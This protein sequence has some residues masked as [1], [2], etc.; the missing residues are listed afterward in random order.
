MKVPAT[1][2]VVVAAGLISGSGCGGGDG[3][4]SAPA[5][6][7]SVTVLPATT[8]IPP[9]ST[10]QL[11]ATSK[12]FNGNVVTG[13]TVTWATSD[14]GV[15]RV[16]PTGLVTG[17][18]AG[19]ATI[20]AMSEGQ[21]GTATVNV[22][23]VFAALTAGFTHTC[24]LTTVGTAYCWGDN[25]NGALGD[26]TDSLRARPTAVRGGLHFATLSAGG[27]SGLSNGTAAG[28][29]TC[30]VTPAGAA[31]CWG[32]NTA[33]ALGT[34][35]SSGPETC[36]GAQ[37]CSTT[38]LAVAGGLQFA[39]VSVGGAHVCGVTIGG[40]AYCWGDN[41]FG[42]LGDGSRNPRPSPGL[43]SGGLTFAAVTAGFTH[44]CGL[45]P[46]GAAYCWGNNS[47]GELGD[48]SASFT[49]T[50]PVAVTG[51]L[52]FATL[53]A[54]GY[55][56]CGATATGAA[57][58]W[59]DNFYGPLGDSTTWLRVNPVPV[60]GGL[61]FVSVTGGY[62]HTCAVGTGGAGYCWGL[63][64]Y[65]QL[66]AG[67]SNFTETT[68]VAIAGGLIFASVSAGAGHTCA[69]TTARVAYCWGLNTGSNVPVKVAYQ[70]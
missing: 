68:P 27:A 63:N 12:D 28:D 25:G 64:S 37:P 38:P 67:S 58:C 61:S 1:L 24:G 15:A 21:N 43:V 31:Y 62:Y 3:I 49:Q 22:V 32:D 34:G 13:R 53:S 11:T 2:S 20:T 42:Q 19:P 5:P 23:V 17:V 39:S 56:T 57:Y 70:P 7:A 41:F 6:V 54:G 33:G 45:T 60:H 55:F 40:A 66:G 18:V 36:V 47:S 30:G 8:A 52:V 51:G 14:T 35:S 44:T 48:P 9:E 26:G 69:L 59:G 50:T 65:G 46:A 4:P 10:L 29:R 16:S